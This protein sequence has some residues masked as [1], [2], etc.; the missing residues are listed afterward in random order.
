[1]IIPDVNLLVYAYTEQADP[2]T[3]AR[4][5]VESMFAGSEAI[6]LPWAV[7]IGFIRVMTLRRA[8]VEPISATEAVAT[9]QRWRRHHLVVIPEPGPNHL[10]I[11]EQSLVDAGRAGNLV[12]DAHL[13]ALAIEHDAEF[14]SYDRDF[15]LFQGL[16]WRDPSARVADD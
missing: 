7:Q 10:E 14:H 9:V 6:G 3:S 13:A 1:M 15:G 11:V 8:V 16:R 5:W 4:P 12:P 2:Y